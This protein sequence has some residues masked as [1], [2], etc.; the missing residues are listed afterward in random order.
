MQ[1]FRAVLE[2]VHTDSAEIMYNN[3]KYMKKVL[4]EQA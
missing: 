2:L 3:S 1:K 4:W